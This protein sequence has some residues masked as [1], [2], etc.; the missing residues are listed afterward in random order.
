MIQDPIKLSLSAVVDES[1]VGANVS[2]S[3]GLVVTEIE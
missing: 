3:L 1:L 2:I